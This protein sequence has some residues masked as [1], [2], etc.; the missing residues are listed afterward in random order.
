MTIGKYRLA[1]NTQR[2]NAKRRGIGWELT[3]EQWLA[4]WGED[5][6]RRGSGECDL[7]MQRV[8][9]AGP[10]ALGNIKKGTPK[11]NS[12]TASIVRQNE[13]CARAAEIRRELAKELM[14]QDCGEKL[15]QTFDEDERELYSMFWPKSSHSM[16]NYKKS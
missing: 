2:H 4:W 5:I 9:D 12:A 3:F 8:A 14:T 7:Q 10:Y 6:E 11:Q 16:L 13:A 15:I 1:F